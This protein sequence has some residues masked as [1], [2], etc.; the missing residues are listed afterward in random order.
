MDGAADKASR[1]AKT[2]D[3]TK[4]R[5]VFVYTE[6][7]LGPVFLPRALSGLGEARTAE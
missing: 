3:A 1:T 6:Y 5:R 7:H 2:P 4:Q